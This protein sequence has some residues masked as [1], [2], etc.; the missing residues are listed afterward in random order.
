MNWEKMLIN[1]PEKYPKRDHINVR[2]FINE[3]KGI[4][5]CHIDWLEVERELMR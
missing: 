4:E 3:M 5:D 2:E 1:L